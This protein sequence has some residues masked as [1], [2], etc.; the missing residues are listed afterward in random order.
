MATERQRARSRQRLQRL[1]ESSLDSDS[2]RYAVI[3]ELQRVIGFDRWCWP[4]ADPETLLPGSGLALHDFGPRVP[5]SLQLEY[6]IDGFVA[7]HAVA[8]RA[9][10]AGSLSA[11]TG[12]DPA[13]SPRWDEVLRPVGIGDV[14]ALACRDELGCWG[15]FEAYRDGADRAFDEADLDLLASVGPSFGRA[16]RRRALGDARVDAGAAFPPGVIVLDAELRPLSWTAGARAW[17]DVLPAA[18]L[19]ERM[20]ILPTVVYPAATLAQSS[21]TVR[22]AHA[23]V[24][25]VNGRWVMIEAAPLE[26][27]A[28]GR[29]A[30]TLREANRSETFELLCRAY[31]LTRRERELVALLVAG[32]DTRMIAQR[33]FIS[34]YT[35]QDHLKAVFTKVDVRSRRELVA[36]LGSTGA[37]TQSPRP[38]GA[39]P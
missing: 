1:S 7:K 6:S 17:F 33:L 13:R 20:G 2:L 3:A 25:A 29:V 36:K 37:E 24:R 27:D 16:L 31:A 9:N 19:V 21:G 18:R 12:G 26:G 30:V 8:R 4:L 11:E 14:V 34:R 32:L 10:P 39:F 28:G 35:V 38:T 23:L 15:W 5:R 22:A